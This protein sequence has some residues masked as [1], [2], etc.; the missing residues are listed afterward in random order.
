[1]KKILLPILFFLPLL[2]FG[3]LPEQ[4]ILAKFTI[5]KALKNGV[6]ITRTIEKAAA[7][8]VFYSNPNNDL[9]YMANV[10]PNSNSQ[11]YGPMYSVEN[12]SFK[13][14]YETNKADFFAFNWK[15]KNDYDN[16]SGIA[17][18]EV[19]KIYKPEGISFTVKII[20]ENLDIIIYSGFMEGTVNFENYNRSPRNH[21]AERFRKDYNIVSFYDMD[22]EQWSDWDDGYNTFVI[23]YNSNGDI[24]HYKPNGEMDLYRK[25]SSVKNDVTISGDQFQIISALDDSGLRFQFQFFDD[26]SIGLKMIYGDQMIQFAE[27]K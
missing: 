15:Y 20:P 7:Y 2:I 25:I 27:K 8:T 23:N 17:D 3:Q 4:E 13:E 21:E 12:K 16:K 11:S 6:D 24:A 19:I 14:T 5:T 22:L 10:W 18:V 26:T 1:M 9:I